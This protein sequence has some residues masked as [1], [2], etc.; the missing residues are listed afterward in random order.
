ME[1]LEALASLGSTRVIWIDDLFGDGATDF[2]VSV[3]S[4]LEVAKACMFPELVE[5]LARYE[6]DPDGGEGLIRQALAD[7]TP[8]RL[9]EMRTAFFAK[10]ALEDHAATDDLS[11]LAR[12]KVC[13]A[14]GV[15]AEDRWTFSEAEQNLKPICDADDS[16]LSYVVDLNDA[17]SRSPTRGLDIL[18]ALQSFN[19]RGTAFILTH[20]TK[21]EQ[22]SETEAALAQELAFE[23]LGFP[24]CVIAKERL[25]SEDGTDDAIHEALRIAVKRAG[26]R[27]SLHEVL[28]EAQGKL[29]DAYLE[30]AKALLRIAPEHLEAHVVERGRKEGVSEMHVVERAI[31]ALLGQ[32]IRQFFGSDKIV[33]SSTARLRALRDIPLAGGG[34]TAQSPLAQF[35]NA[36]V[37]EDDTLINGAMTPLACGDVFE[38]DGLEITSEPTDRRFLLLGPPCDIALRSDGKRDADT[39]FFIP[40]KRKTAVQGD[41]LK[42]PPLQFQIQSEHWVCDFRAASHANLSIL[43]LATFRPDGRVRVDDGHST[44]EALLPGQKQAYAKRTGAAGTTLTKKTVGDRAS[45]MQL[46]FSC[47]GPFSRISAATLAVKSDREEVDG[48]VVDALPLRVTWK[49]RRC[50]R[51]RMPYAAA[52]LDQ[53]LG[54]LG[55]AAFDLD[56]MS[57]GVDEHPPVSASPADKSGGVDPEPDAAPPH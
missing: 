32:H 30:A 13:T 34:L 14:L 38:M 53:Y 1:V 36:E 56:F 21:A 33:R 52:I 12:D 10:A 28:K 47:A 17:A 16:E 18:R 7:V 57:P 55:R 27:K 22:E 2:S 31:T 29:S 44:S 50:G 37:W 40:L 24:L 8:D 9:S 46:T 51:V 20:E 11:A 48:D 54:V 3:I 19:S 15:S 39:A 26:L 43:D 6:L 35:R 4:G 23:G 49:L 5:A 41:K 42:E 45:K 25:H